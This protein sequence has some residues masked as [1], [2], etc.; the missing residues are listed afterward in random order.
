VEKHIAKIGV[1]ATI[2]TPVYFMDNLAMF[3]PR[4]GKTAVGK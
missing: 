3:S 4:E 1:R 2:L